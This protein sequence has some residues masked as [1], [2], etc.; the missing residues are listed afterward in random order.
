MEKDP[1]PLGNC[2]ASSYLAKERQEDARD[3]FFPAWATNSE[4]KPSNLARPKYAHEGYTHYSN[5]T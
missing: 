5:D 4:P 2:P 1:V 3:F